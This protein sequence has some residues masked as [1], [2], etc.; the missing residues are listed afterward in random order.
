VVS[1]ISNQN[2]PSTGLSIP[3]HIPGT[4]TALSLAHRR[5]WTMTPTIRDTEKRRE[6]SEKYLS[7]SPHFQKCIYIVVVNERIVK[8]RKENQRGK[9]SS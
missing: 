2:L 1:F 3:L 6:S 4:S 7:S 9:F 5:H 8:N